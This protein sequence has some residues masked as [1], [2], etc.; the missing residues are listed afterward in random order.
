ME[1]LYG[2]QSCLAPSACER[3]KNGK[4]ISTVM[5]KWRMVNVGSSSITRCASILAR[6]SAESF[7]RRGLAL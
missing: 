3:N 7:G 2:R 5:E 6:S 1:R 4:S